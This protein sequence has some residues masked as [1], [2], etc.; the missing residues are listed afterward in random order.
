MTS[1]P[2]HHC[3][4]CGRSFLNEYFHIQRGGELVR[5]AD[6]DESFVRKGYVPG[7]VGVAWICDAHLH[8]AWER[9]NLPTDAAISEMLQQFESVPKLPVERRENPEL[10][11]IDVGPNRARV[12]TIVRQA[13]GASPEATR[14]LPDH[15]PT[16]I[17]EGWPISFEHSRCQLRDAGAITE[18]RWD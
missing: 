3:A 2:P 13:T 15:L 9:V 1:F 18:I 17:A 11:L 7:V 8:A 5:F 6:F 16:K 10:F 14:N 4:I 12:F